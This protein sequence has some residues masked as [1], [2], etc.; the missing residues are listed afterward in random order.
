MLSSKMLGSMKK[1]GNDTGNQQLDGESARSADSDS[2]VDLQ[3]D[4]PEALAARA[5]V[6]P[7]RFTPCVVQICIDADHGY[8]RELSASRA[9]Q[10]NKMYVY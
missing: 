8:N 1:R 4:T 3:G 6:W 9:V 2:A 10:D 7:I 5:V